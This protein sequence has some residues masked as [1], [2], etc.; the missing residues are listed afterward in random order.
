[1]P[2]PNYDAGDYSQG[3]QDSY[4][5]RGG[6][7]LRGRGGPRG[8]G[9]GRGG[10]RGGRARG[11]PRGGPRGGARGGQT[12]GSHVPSSTKTSE[13]QP[14][15]KCEFFSPLSFLEAWN[16]KFFS[17]YA[18]ML[19]TAIGLSVSSILPLHSLVSG[20]RLIHCVAA[21]KTITENT[22]V[23]NV[24]RFGYRIPLRC[25]PVQHKIPSN[26]S[27][28]GDAHQV[29][30]EEA[31]GLLKKGAVREVKDVEGQY[32]SSY[33]AVPKPRS[34]KWR[35]IINLKRFNENI[36]HFK[37]KMECFKQLREL[38]QPNS[39]LIGI[40]LKDQF[41]SVSI[42]PSY[43]K[44]LRFKWLDKLFEWCSLPFGL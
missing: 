10:A 36:K 19:I 25:K 39:Y 30:V 16:G 40:D 2:P 6:G 14:Q 13:T 38:I 11:G 41:L 34:T 22:W 3:T 43:R 8:G 5:G 7:P 4:R 33:F 20:G 28:T 9:G 21:W 27:S 17:A 24:V 31:L 44:F 37:F 32:I 23:R 15:Q 12:G 1:M 29:L 42:N 18:I 35:P 26:P